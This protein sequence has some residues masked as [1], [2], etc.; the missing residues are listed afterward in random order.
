MRNRLY[1]T[2]YFT[3]TYVIDFEKYYN[4]GYRAVI[5]DVDNTLTDF[6]YLSDEK[7]EYL[8]G[9]KVEIAEL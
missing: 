5:F 4:M 9:S 6:A 7:K 8:N 1:P 2:D 3:S